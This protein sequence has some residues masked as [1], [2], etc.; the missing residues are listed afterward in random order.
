MPEIIPFL[1]HYCRH[2]HASMTFIPKAF[3][4]GVRVLLAALRR[5][6]DGVVLRSQSKANHR[7]VIKLGQQQ[8]QRREE[9]EASLCAPSRHASETATEDA[10]IS[11]N[12][13][14]LSNREGSIL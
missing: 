13:Y 9:E 3:L 6:K 2:S 14:H 4:S 8:I 12:S 7:G 5:K 10:E 11:S 1:H